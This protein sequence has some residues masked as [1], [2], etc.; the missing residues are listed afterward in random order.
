ME[1]RHLWLIRSCAHWTDPES[2]SRLALAAKQ[3][4][5]ADEEE[6]WRTLASHLVLRPLHLDTEVQPFSK[7]CAT[8]PSPEDAE[9]IQD[10]E[11]ATLKIKI[12]QVYYPVFQV[13][14]R[15]RKLW[16]SIKSL[17]ETVL[18]EALDS[19]LPGLTEQE[20]EELEERLGCQ[21]PEDLAESL[22]VHEGM[23][24]SGHRKGQFLLEL[25][26]E[27]TYTLSTVCLRA[28][29][30]LPNL[31]E[32]AESSAR[33]IPRAHS[34]TSFQPFARRGD[35]SLTAIA[36]VAEN[37]YGHSHWLPLFENDCLSPFSP[38]GEPQSQ[39]VLVAFPHRGRVTLLES[40]GQHEQR[41]RRR[42]S[43][44]GSVQYLHPSGAVGFLKIYYRDGP[45]WYGHATC[46][47]DFLRESLE[48]LEA[49][50]S[51]WSKP[52]SGCN[53][54][55]LGWHCPQCKR[56]VGESFSQ[57][58]DRVL[59]VAAR[60]SEPLPSQRTFNRYSWWAS[61]VRSCRWDQP[62]VAK[63]LL[64][65]KPQVCP[66]AMAQLWEVVGGV[67]KGGIL[68]R[69]GRELASREEDGR[70]STGALVRQEELVGER[71]RYTRLTGTGPSSGWVSLKVKDKPMVVKSDRT[72]PL[73]PPKAAAKAEPETTASSPS[74]ADP[75]DGVGDETAAAPV[76]E[77]DTRTAAS[78]A[79]VGDVNFED[80][81][82][83]DS[84]PSKEPSAPAEPAPTPAPASDAAPPSNGELGIGSQVEIK[85]LKSKPELNGR[86]A[87]VMSKDEAAGRFEVKLDGPSDDRVRCKP[88]N[89]QVVLAKTSPKKAQGDAN[90][91]EGRYD[92][93][94]SCYREALQ[95]AKDDTEFAATIQSNIAAAFATKGDHQKALEAANEAIRLRPDWAK[96]HS[97]KGFSLTHAILRLAD[98]TGSDASFYKVQ[99]PLP[100][101]C[102]SGTCGA[103]LFSLVENLLVQN[104]RRDREELPAL[105][106]LSSLI[107]SAD[108]G[109]RTMCPSPENK[110]YAVEKPVQGDL[111]I[112]GFGFGVHPEYQSCSAVI[113]RVDEQHC[114]VAVLDPSRGFR[115]GDCQVAFRDLRPVHQEWRA[116]ARLVIGGLQSS[117][118]RH[119]N[120]RTV[121]VCEHR[122]Y[123]HPCFVQPSA[124]Q[125]TKEQK[126]KLTLCVRL[127]DPI[128][129]HAT[130]LLL[131][132]RFLS[133]YIPKE[134][135][136]PTVPKLCLPAQKEATGTLLSSSRSGSSRGETDS[137]NSP[138]SRSRRVP[139]TVEGNEYRTI[140]KNFVVFMASHR[141]WV[142]GF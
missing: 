32:D 54:D 131:E 108:D 16:K 114:M 70:L 12:L 113:T 31:V 102:Q 116:G 100:V 7:V 48:M 18:P 111:V 99:M 103:G 87:T 37:S 85:G 40:L 95:E 141:Y 78:N 53:V 107:V 63:R 88:E 42:Y 137:K 13:R 75:E 36:Y 21:F 127:D 124:S 123:G 93:A 106:R 10:A 86:R 77:E 112:L 2:L 46:F 35:V 56:I 120:G 76:V 57:A 142:H 45:T 125:G 43:S 9:D 122:R 49:I 50:Q 47:E 55:W 58:L 29:R 11:D 81:E 5:Q 38:Y 129:D 130:A 51:A 65:I 52:C 39:N 105:C 64:K 128:P 80:D 30:D 115:T 72:E 91:K 34:L 14:N 73:D 140:C 24:E 71:L 118:M 69:A 15:V 59:P 101:S 1:S 19:L 92:Q 132:P 3:L 25:A 61:V 98:L 135:R 109:G 117:K 27:D 41:P 139:S 68:V 6:H 74:A 23:R 96:A 26:R 119:L 22:R 133:P 4:Q 20:I 121:H 67:D 33:K 83:Q 110:P 82:E 28:A 8:S 84:S 44:S 97:R 126:D 90:F 138:V 134:E 17:W 104:N 136:A 62:F 79:P 94:V 89:L 66:R 60:P